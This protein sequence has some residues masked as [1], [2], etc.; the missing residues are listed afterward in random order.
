MN[1]FQALVSKR[2]TRKEQFMGAQIEISKLTAQEV[3]ELQEFIAS[4]AAKEDEL[5]IIR[6][7]I[8]ASVADAADISDKDFGSFPLDELSKLTEAIL[9]FS[10][11]DQGAKGKQA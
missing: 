10:G 7:V 2:I 3:K 1:P 5:S 4:D 8:R 6:H 9:K 11:L